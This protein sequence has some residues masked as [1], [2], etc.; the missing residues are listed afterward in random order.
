MLSFFQTSPSLKEIVFALSLLGLAGCK[1]AEET[2]DSGI[3]L[4]RDCGVDSLEDVANL[5]TLSDECKMA[6]IEL[7]PEFEDNLANALVPLGNK[8]FDGK[9]VLFFAAANSDGSPLTTEKAQLIKVTAISAEAETVL[10]TTQYALKKLREYSGH[11]IAVSAIV[12]Y[13]GSMNDADL[14]DAA[15]IY[16]DLFSALQ[17]TSSFEA[18]V[19]FFSDSVSEIQTFTDDATIIQQALQVDIDYERGGTALFDAIGTGLTGLADRDEPIRL[20][21]IATDGLENASQVYTQKDALYKLAREQRIPVIILGALLA[22]L[23]LLRKMAKETN[24]VFMYNRLFLYLKRDISRLSTILAESIA[25]ELR[26]QEEEWERIRIEAN[27][28]RIELPL[29][30]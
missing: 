4:V 6:L 18:N 2:I 29:L 16:H 23:P 3:G 20:L 28:K 12:D 17:A 19:L 30:R 22:D 13:S 7:L 24:G 5:R 25:L 21:V 11:N 27:D 14:A 26:Q 1:L 10:D 15:E 9:S 8:T